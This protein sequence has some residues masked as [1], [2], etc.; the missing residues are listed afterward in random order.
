MQQERQT[1]PSPGTQGALGYPGISA[2]KSKEHTLHLPNLS[3]SVPRPATSAR[4][5]EPPLVAAS[6][7]FTLQR[8]PYLGWFS[9]PALVYEV[10]SQ[11]YF[12]TDPSFSALAPS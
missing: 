10:P 12:H 6:F 11:A 4:L 7:P 9:K 3:P 2:P 5:R 1:L 8:A